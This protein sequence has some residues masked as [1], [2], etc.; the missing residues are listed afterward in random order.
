MS[1]SV[2]HRKIKDVISVK[3][4]EWLGASIKEYPSSGHL[5]DIYAVTPGG[6]SIYIEII[7]SSSPQNFFRDLNLIQQSDANIK[8]VIAS[9]Q[10]LKNTHFCREFS[11]VVVA[12]RRFGVMMYGELLDGQKILENPEYLE[13]TVKKI[14]LDF[15][16]NI[17]S[18]SLVIPKAGFKPPE[19]PK[20]DKVQEKLVSNLFPVK[21]YPSIIY[22]GSTN[23]RKESEVF[24]ILGR[25]VVN[26]LFILKRK[27]LYT[28]ENL[29]NCEN[30][31][32]SIIKGE[33]Q[34]EPFSE[35]MQSKEKRYDVVRLL[36]LAL[37]I[38]CL[39]KLN[40]NYDKKHRR[41]IC[42]LKDGKDN[43]FRWR[44]GEKF[45]D[46]TIAKVFYS[47]K[48][49]PLFCRHYSAELRFMFINGRL[50]LKI[51][52]TIVFTRDGYRP[53][54][55]EK[56][57]YLMSR[58]LSKQ[59]N[60]QYLKLVRFWAKYLSKLDIVIT[61]PVGEQKII[62]DT[63]PV[64]TRINVGILKEELFRYTGKEE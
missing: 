46:R 2:E 42:P 58:W 55:S 11:K 45:V 36:N 64:V 49:K 8:L 26:Y 30:P 17:R 24:D 33:V 48:G 47:K 3:L 5:L 62:I 38:Y 22:S 50:F 59:Y 63:I 52:P 43:V 20:A 40:L 25:R 34:E 1:E 32:L 60:D 7:W 37:R 6:I 54:H 12:Q 16:H 4:K 44:A 23:L 51:E 31:F 21:E 14:V 29:K 15:I 56:M 41:F 39:N 61:I 18:G 28:F 10:V 35:W 57:A 27:R 13:K 53:F 9:P 19:I